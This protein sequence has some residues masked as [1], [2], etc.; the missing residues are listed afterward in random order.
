VNC[1]FKPLK[2]ESKLSY[3]R[4]S[5]GQF[6]LVSSTHQAPKTRF[7]LLSVSFSLLMW[8]ALSDERMGLSF[9]MLLIFASTVIL[10][11]ESH[12]THDHILLP[13]IRDSPN[14][15]RGPRIYIPQKQGG[16]VIL[17]GTGFPFRRLLRLAG[18]RWRYLTPPLRVD[19]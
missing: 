4:R 17:P 8:G 14:L 19:S 11:T 15:G 3:D 5:H 13:Q 1:F 6:I 7:L 9:T 2:N 18:L 12:G 10:G 16:P